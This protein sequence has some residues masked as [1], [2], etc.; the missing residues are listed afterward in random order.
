MDKSDFFGVYIFTNTK[1]FLF[2]PS[3][4]TFT[5]FWLVCCLKRLLFIRS[6]NEPESRQI[7]ANVVENKSLSFYLPSLML[8]FE[9]DSIRIVCALCAMQECKRLEKIDL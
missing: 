3:K 4:E 1:F 6:T 2:L 7:E 9:L 5:S 8:T